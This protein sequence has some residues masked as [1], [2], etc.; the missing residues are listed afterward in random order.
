MHNPEF[1]PRLN[2]PRKALHCLEI[3]IQN[4]GIAYVNH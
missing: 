3:D 2:F 1:L 4:R